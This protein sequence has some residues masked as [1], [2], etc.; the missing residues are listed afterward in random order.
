ME[1]KIEVDEKQF[2]QIFNDTL[3]SLPKEKLEEI[4]LAGMKE[5]LTN[6]NV[7]E[8]LL[9]VKSGYYSNN[10]SPSPFLNNIIDKAVSTDKLNE[11]RDQILDEFQKN[12]QSIFSKAITN[13]IFRSLF[14]GNE[15]VDAARSAAS[16]IVYSTMADHINNK[17]S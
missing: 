14:T 10:T 6:K 9:T 7:M 2:N 15:F 13:T 17:H 11:V 5:Y 16:E 3:A 8:S 4:V 1:I 12:Y